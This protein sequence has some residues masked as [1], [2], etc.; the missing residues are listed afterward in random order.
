MTLSISDL[1]LFTDSACP[2]Q[3][4]GST[5]GGQLADYDVFQA[6]KFSDVFQHPPEALHRGWPR[7]GGGMGSKAGGSQGASL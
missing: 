6:T 3:A 7:S 5:R 2:T 4:A 1:C